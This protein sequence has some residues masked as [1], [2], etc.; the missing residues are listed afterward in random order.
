MDSHY[1][2]KMVWRPSDLYNGNWQTIFI[3]RRGPVSFV[4]QALGWRHN[5]HDGVS[6]HQPHHCLLNQL[7]RRRSKKISK[8]PV[9]GLWAG[10]SPVT[11]EFPTQMA[12]YAEFWWRHH[13]KWP[14]QTAACRHWHGITRNLTPLL[15]QRDYSRRF[16]SIQWLL[17]PWHLLLPWLRRQRY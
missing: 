15:L 13:R 14:Q 12:S 8:L 2:D 1:E 7:V 17:L 9:T 3:F 4:A 6:T 10:Y 16:R 11:G 5:G